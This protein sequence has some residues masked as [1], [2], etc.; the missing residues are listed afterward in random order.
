MLAAVPLAV[1][2]VWS[3][4]WPGLLAGGAEAWRPGVG[5]GGERQVRAK[6]A[7]GPSESAGHARGWLVGQRHCALGDGVVAGERERAAVALVACGAA[8]SFATGLE[9]VSPL[10]LSAAAWH[11]RCGQSVHMPARGNRVLLTQHCQANTV[12]V[13]GRAARLQARRRGPHHP[14]PHL[15]RAVQRPWTL[16]LVQV[17]EIM[18]VLVVVLVAVVAVV[19]LL[20]YPSPV[21]LAE[22][23]KTMGQRE[24]RLWGLQS[25]GGVGG[26]VER[27][28]GG[29]SQ[30]RIWP[31]CWAPVHRVSRSRSWRQRR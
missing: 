5:R 9:I 30:Q 26:C 6:C 17:P 2:W 7:S 19:V 10:T 16:L 23:V 3:G 31:G 12:T 25:G 8:A 20:G 13:S 21:A 27:G 28:R 11:C 18:L 22:A 29:A 4:I 24:I 15:Q 14:L 1:A